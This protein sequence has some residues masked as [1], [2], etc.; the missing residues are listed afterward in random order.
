[1][2]DRLA[3]SELRTRRRRNMTK[4]DKAAWWRSRGTPVGL[5]KRKLAERIEDM[6]RQTRTERQQDYRREVD[7]HKQRLREIMADGHYVYAE[8]W[9]RQHTRDGEHA[10]AEAIEEMIA[11]INKY[12][13]E[14]PAPRNYGMGDDHFE[15][16]RD[17]ERRR[18]EA[19]DNER[20]A[21]LIE[22]ARRKAAGIGG[23]LDAA[24]RR[25]EP[26]PE[27]EGPSSE[28]EEHEGLRRALGVH[29][30]LS[31]TP[32]APGSERRSKRRK[33]YTPPPFAG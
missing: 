15:R 33:R 10:A 8:Q 30:V 24:N 1:M 18:Q 27:D 14:H 31:R 6:A 5:Q 29:G 28:A 26:E 12:N 2:S 11:E 25:T 7:A 3:P 9:Y 21:A 23:G 4:Q 17:L 22:G 19:R 13:R 20:V 16:T 32:L